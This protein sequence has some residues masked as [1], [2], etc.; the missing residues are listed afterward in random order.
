MFHNVGETTRTY[1]MQLRCQIATI[2][3]RPVFQMRLKSDDLWQ[4]YI[5]MESL[6]IHNESMLN[7]TPVNVSLSLLVSVWCSLPF[8][9][10]TYLSLYFCWFLWIESVWLSSSWLLC[11]LFPSLFPFFRK[12]VLW[13]FLLVLLR[14]V[15]FWWHSWAIC[16]SLEAEMVVKKI[17]PS[18]GDG[19]IGEVGSILETRDSCF[20][21]V[22]YSKVSKVSSCSTWLSVPIHLALNLV[23]LPGSH[24][25]LNIVYTLYTFV[26]PS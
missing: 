21:F 17:N 13:I 20:S 4:K 7:T 10:S 23:F 24:L 12:L 9:Y 25:Y 16:K 5:V 11:L 6:N 3:P 15:R 8:S 14:I 2:L 18:S 22:V 26:C 1:P 19:M